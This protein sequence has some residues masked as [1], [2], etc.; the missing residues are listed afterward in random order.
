[1]RL[2][3]VP[4]GSD[5][6]SDAGSKTAVSLLGD[7]DGPAAGFS[8]GALAVSFPSRII[9]AAVSASGSPIVPLSASSLHAF[10]ASKIFNRGYGSRIF[11]SIPSL[12]RRVGETGCEV[13]KLEIRPRPPTTT[14]RPRPQSKLAERPRPDRAD[15]AALAA[16]L[17]AAAHQRS[18]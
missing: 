11:R 14:A 1:A 7:T 16:A 12:V 3:F 8:A 5:P 18:T 17:P 6:D 13:S 10:L 9:A 15:A 2:S 4:A